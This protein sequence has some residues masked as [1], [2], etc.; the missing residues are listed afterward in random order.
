M[1]DGGLREIEATIQ[2]GPRLMPLL[3]AEMQQR[4]EISESGE[5]GTETSGVEEESSEED[6]D[7]DQH[8]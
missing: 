8:S 3:R 1:L 4:M 7:A 6:E 5:D 2:L